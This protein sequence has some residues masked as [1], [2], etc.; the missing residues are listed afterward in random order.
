MKDLWEFFNG[1]KRVIGGVCFLVSLFLR[2]FIVGIWEYEPD[3]MEK[4]ILSFDWLGGAFTGTGIL[5]K[6]AKVRQE[7]LKSNLEK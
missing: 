6:A 4:L 5:H 3:W 1:K 2:Q 7:K